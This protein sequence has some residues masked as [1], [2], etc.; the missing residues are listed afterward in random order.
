MR[1]KVTFSH[2][3]LCLS[4]NVFGLLTP[5]RTAAAS[6]DYTVAN[7]SG[8]AWEY[9]YSVR[10][11]LGFDIEEFT[12]YFDYLLYANL[13][14]TAFPLGWN[15]LVVEPDA[16]IPDDGFFD[17]CSNTE[18]CGGAGIGI[19]HGASLAGFSISFDYFGSGTPG[20]QS[21]EIVHPDTFEVLDMGLTNVVVPAPTSALLLST[22][23]G[24]ALGW[25]RR[26]H[27]P[28][29]GAKTARPC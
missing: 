16:G 4:V 13:A 28:R 8:S 14:V 20:G 17:A 9:S 6:I 27:R 12:I 1:R 10:N 25:S 29:Y 21:F 15:S 18:L 11:D 19:A 23:L 24:A 7:I 5:D 22:A 3:L 2:I 26:R